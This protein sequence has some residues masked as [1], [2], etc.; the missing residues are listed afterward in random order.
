M[1]SYFTTFISGRFRED[2][3]NTA[4]RILYD[5]RAVVKNSISYF[6]HI[7]LTGNEEEE[8]LNMSYNNLRVYED[9]DTL[10]FLGNNPMLIDC[11]TAD[12]SAAFLALSGSFDNFDGFDPDYFDDMSVSM[13]I[14]VEQRIRNHM[15]KKKSHFENSYSND[16]NFNPYS[17]SPKKYMINSY[18]PIDKTLFSIDNA[19]KRKP[20][21]W[22]QNS[23]QIGNNVRKNVKDLE[24]FSIYDDSSC[25]QR[26]NLLSPIKVSSRSDM[27]PHFSSKRL[28]NRSAKKVSMIKTNAFYQHISLASTILKANVCDIIS[29]S[30]NNSSFSLRYNDS[31]LIITDSLKSVSTQTYYSVSQNILFEWIRGVSLAG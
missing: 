28:G 13:S 20:T 10:C 17:N 16:E 26:P 14:D 8:P 6:E 23:L 7:M 4:G 2:D 21:G 27:S 22:M 31:S 1:S 24:H 30:S 3:V 18:P 9:K 25:A 15:Y 19:S 5:G 11:D 12:S 29:H